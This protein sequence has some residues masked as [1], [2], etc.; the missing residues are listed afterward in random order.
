MLSAAG[1]WGKKMHTITITHPAGPGQG[2]VI[3]SAGENVTAAKALWCWLVENLQPGWVV[4]LSS[5]DG[6]AEL[7]RPSGEPL[8]AE[9]YAA[10]MG[11]NAQPGDIDAAVK[12]WAG[13]RFEWGD[14]D[15][16]LPTFEPFEWD[17]EPFEWPI[18]KPE[19]EAGND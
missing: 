3:F 5:F 18:D 13:A 15:F 11:G 14:F 7:T 10:I 4:D 16:E 17:F 9:L 8:P 19:G 12:G 2:G 1:A 6:A